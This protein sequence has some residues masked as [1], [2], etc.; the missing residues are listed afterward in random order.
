M[1][2]DQLKTELERAY[3]AIRG[4]YTAQRQGVV[5]TGAM[6]AY[7]SPTVGAACHFVATGELVG[8]EHFIGK[9]I[10]ALQEALAR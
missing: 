6:M 3:R 8:A 10:E 1:T 2:E 5:P 4:F 9:P 7:H